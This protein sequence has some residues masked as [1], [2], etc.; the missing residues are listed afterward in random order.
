V[1]PPTLRPAPP[2]R[3]PLLDVRGFM[4]GFALSCAMGAVLYIYLIVG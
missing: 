1:T 4:A 2:A 3:D